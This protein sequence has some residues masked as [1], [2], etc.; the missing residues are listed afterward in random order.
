M[1]RVRET[2][3]VRRM[4]PRTEE[5]YVGWMR[6][7]V[8]YHGR[9]HPRDLDV[10][11]I[12]RFLLHLAAEQQGAASTQN[13]ALRRAAAAAMSEGLRAGDLRQVPV[14]IGG[15]AGL[16]AEAREERADSGAENMPHAADSTGLSSGVY[17]GLRRVVAS[18]SCGT[19]GRIS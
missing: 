17:A 2:M 14:R 4:S 15:G 9:R 12:A 8:D 19:F 5:A 3:R 18:G 10:D 11:A 7:F 1:D 13:Q 6:R 16:G